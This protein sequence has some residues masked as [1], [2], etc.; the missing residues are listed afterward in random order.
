M[1]GATFL[2]AVTL[3]CADATPTDKAFREW[4]DYFVGGTWTATDARGDKFSSRGEWILNKSFVKVSWQI[5]GDAGESVTGIDPA[6]GKVHSWGFDNKGRTWSVAVTIKVPGEW[7]EEGPGTARGGLRNAWKMKA[8]KLGPDKHK[9]DILENVIDGKAFPP[10]AMTLERN[11]T[12]DASARGQGTTAAAGVTPAEKA[13]ADYGN[14][15]VGGTWT[16]TN[17]K[18]EAMESRY[19]WILDK[20][21]LALHGKEGAGEFAE[22]AGIDPATGKW[23]VWGFDK[24]GLVYKGTIESTKPGQYAYSLAGTGPQGAF[25]WKA[26]ETKVGEDESKVAISEYVADGKKRGP[27]TYS[28][29]RKK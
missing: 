26:V 21:F 18:G 2:L 4:G 7:I 5:T 15:Q 19:Q 10:E 1:F 12:T 24:T 14:W 8:T 20:K 9:V 28:V 27:E 13:F 29:R 3:V 17:A 25:S 11:R 22:V 23:A 16:G 6:T